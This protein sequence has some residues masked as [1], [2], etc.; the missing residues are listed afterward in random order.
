MPE[1]HACL[2]H[3]LKTTVLNALARIVFA[4]NSLW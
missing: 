4:G 1:E 2:P 3:F